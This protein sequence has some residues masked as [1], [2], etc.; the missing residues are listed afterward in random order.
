MDSDWI[1]C[2]PWP[3]HCGQEKDHLEWPMPIAICPSLGSEVKTIQA[4]AGSNFQRKFRELQL[5][6][7]GDAE[8]GINKCPFK[9]PTHECFD[10]MMQ[11]RTE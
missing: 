10:D 4:I 3:N 9:G 11:V 8:E 1:M 7:C 2:P 6:E 5:V